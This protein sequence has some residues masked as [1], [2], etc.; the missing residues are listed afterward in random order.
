MEGLA[1]LS[2]AQAE[3]L[4]SQGKAIAAKLAHKPQG[5]LKAAY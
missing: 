4:G 3:K 1:P 5:T 2:P